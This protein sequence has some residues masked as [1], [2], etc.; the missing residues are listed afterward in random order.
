[1]SSRTPGSRVSVNY[2]NVNASSIA[3]M[4][5]NAIMSSEFQLSVLMMGFLC[6]ISNRACWKHGHSLSK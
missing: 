1:M 4:C 6:R 5:E 3:G 2:S